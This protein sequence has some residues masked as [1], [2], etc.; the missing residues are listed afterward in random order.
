MP[1]SGV[2][3][4]DFKKAEPHSKKGEASKDSSIDT[5]DKGGHKLDRN[6]SRSPQPP[7]LLVFTGD[8]NKQ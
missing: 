3:G 4:K 8:P 2:Y 7:K 5:S 6:R 1:K